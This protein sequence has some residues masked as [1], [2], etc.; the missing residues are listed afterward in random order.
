MV[1]GLTFYMIT[2]QTPYL[3]TSKSWGL[4][5]HGNNYGPRSDVLYYNLTQPLPTS[6]KELDT[7]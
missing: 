5:K 6:V 3:Q 4:S 7:L 2:R 1:L